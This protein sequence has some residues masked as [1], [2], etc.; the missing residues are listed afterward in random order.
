MIAVSVTW[1]AKTR[2]PFTPSAWTKSSSTSSILSISVLSALRVA[3]RSSQSATNVENDAATRSSASG[4]RSQ[5][6]QSQCRRWSRWSGR[7]CWRSARRLRLRRPSLPG[8]LS[9]LA[10][11]SVVTTEAQP[12]A[13]SAMPSTK[14]THRPVELRQPTIRSTVPTAQ[15]LEMISSACA[16][17]FGRLNTC[18]ITPSSSMRNVVRCRPW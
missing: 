6:R 18:W 17:V 12:S 2:P 9:R 10:S 1:P 7:Q 13:S 4:S 5:C 3:L 8:R 15:S 14:A 11:P 16:A